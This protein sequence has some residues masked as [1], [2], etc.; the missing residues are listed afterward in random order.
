MTREALLE[1]L[2][3]PNV[4]AFLRVIREGESTQDDRAYRM[5]FGGE[6]FDEVAGGW[7]HPRRP[8]TKPL[9]GTPI[10]STAAGAYQFLARTWA[11][12]EQRYAIP[13]FSPPW[14]DFGAVALIAGRRALDA[15]IGGRL[16]EALRLCAREW[17]SLPGSPYGQPTITRE[18][19][20]EIFYLYGGTV[21]EA[22]ELPKGRPPMNPAIVLP[23][24]QVAAQA[25]PA[26]GS[27]F[28]SSDTAKRN[29]AAGQVVA[30]ALVKATESATLTEAV[31][32]ITESPEAARLAE[33]AIKPVLYELSEAGGGGIAKAREAAL[34]PGQVPFWRNPAV[35]ISFAILPLVYM[36]ALAVLFG[37]GGQSWSD[38][39][40][41]LLVTAIV[42]GV[43]GAVTGFFLGSSMG[44]QRKD[45]AMLGRP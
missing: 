22:A 28:A 34:D 2:K 1:A 30:E 11:G 33:A 38:D 25:I 20:R 45:A 8:V 39:I 13:D 18:K 36:V 5:M 26:L 40:K 35:L 32:R 3:H 17:A 23:L 21:A 10:T 27:L 12:L 43:L 14:Q 31:G 9:G 4:I 7:R 29:V 37:V 16:D 24:L 42:T 19:A 41:T 15:V 44:S 6:L